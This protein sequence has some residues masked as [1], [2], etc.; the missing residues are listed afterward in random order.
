MSYIYDWSN[1]D[2]C[3]R[4][5]RGVS[6]ENTTSSSTWMV[7]TICETWVALWREVGLSD[8]FEEYLWTNGYYFTVK[9]ANEAYVAWVTNDFG[10]DV[11]TTTLFNFLIQ[12]YV[13][14]NA[15]LIAS[16]L[17]YPKR[18]YIPSNGK[19][20]SKEAK[21]KWSKLNDKETFINMHNDYYLESRWLTIPSCNESDR[22]GHQKLW[23]QE[24]LALGARYPFDRVGHRHIIDSIRK[25]AEMV[26]PKSD[27]KKIWK[28]LY[29][30]L[31]DESFVKLPSGSTADCKRDTVSII[32]AL[33]KALGEDAL[34]GWEPVETGYLFTGKRYVEEVF[35]DD[36][37][38][39]L[40]RSEPF[41]RIVDVPKSGDAKRIIGPVSAVSNILCHWLQVILYDYKPRYRYVH[42]EL[43]HQEVNRELAREG[44][45]FGNFAT[46]DLTA[47]SDSIARKQF[48]ATTPSYQHDLLIRTVPNK[49]YL[50]GSEV[51]VQSIGIS[52]AVTTYFVESFYFGNILEYVCGFYYDFV[53]EKD[54]RAA[55]DDLLASGGYLAAV[56]GDDIAIITPLAQFVIE[57]LTALGQTV[58]KSKTFDE[59]DFR[60]SC[61]G[62]YISGF[63]V[64]P[65]YFPRRPVTATAVKDGKLT[66]KDRDFSSHWEANE[67]SVTTSLATVV[68]AHNALYQ[69]P[70]V[71][72]PLRKLIDKYASCTLTCS[73]DAEE[74]GLKSMDET[75]HVVKYALKPYSREAYKSKEVKTQVKGEWVRPILK[76]RY[77]GDTNYRWMSETYYE[78]ESVTIQYSKDKFALEG[79]TLKHPTSSFMI[80]A[81]RNKVYGHDYEDRKVTHDDFVERVYMGPKGENET[82]GA[83]H[84]PARDAVL[85]H[86]YLAEGPQFEDPL[87]KL[88]GVSSPRTLK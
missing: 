73:N 85:Y 15:K 71:Q 83:G 75:L 45:I 82:Y 70:R 76:P 54:E 72:V 30:R 65:I 80:G 11:L 42:F 51:W 4:V 79:K 14:T 81:V 5:L 36:F 61:G 24:R 37:L 67:V 40:A 53:A 6:F 69:W 77:P 55:I 47:A 57:I 64:T 13:G 9:K 29:M 17:Q 22:A 43:S 31:K 16:C 21:I 8:L 34:H 49:G 74:T 50:D 28:K 1:E 88:L 20:A 41:M 39:A 66:I 58:N 52:G 32:K 27:V 19:N 26:M 63:D 35:I 25:T 46:I 60:E 78:R 10:S 48:E 12:K 87:M 86:L 3:K 56:K 23:A 2:F 84:D 62:N 7:P 44:S 38:N 68:S 33:Y 18:V 59:G